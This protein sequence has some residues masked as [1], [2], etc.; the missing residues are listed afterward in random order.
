MNIH[1]DELLGKLPIAWVYKLLKL[2]T[3]PSVRRRYIHTTEHLVLTW[4]DISSFVLNSYSARSLLPF[5][6]WSPLCAYTLLSFKNP[7]VFVEESLWLENRCH[8][9]LSRCLYDLLR[10]TMPCDLARGRMKW[11]FHWHTNCRFIAFILGAHC[12]ITF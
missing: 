5:A 1:N 3:C 7:I 11:S 2:W 12:S 10:T 9:E 4:T 6:L 8:R